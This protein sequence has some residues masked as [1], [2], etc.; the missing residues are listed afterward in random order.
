M[1][2]ESLCGNGVV[3]LLVAVFWVFIGGRLS[4]GSQKHWLWPL[5]GSLGS[6]LLVEGC[7]SP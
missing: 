3:V 4:A 5:A 1:F 6:V 7:L 2:M